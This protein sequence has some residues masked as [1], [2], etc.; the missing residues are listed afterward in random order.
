MDLDA[1][2]RRCSGHDVKG[3]VVDPRLH[4]LV[5]RVDDIPVGRRDRLR[6]TGA[7]VRLHPVEDRVD[8]HPEAVGLVEGQAPRVLGK[9]GA[10]AVELAAQA[11]RARSP[12][13][14]CRWPC[15]TAGRRGRPRP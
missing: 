10:E 14:P 6:D 5:D 4:V 3:P 15:C 9:L 1:Q 2:A 11:S 7:E 13:A 8:L 12:S